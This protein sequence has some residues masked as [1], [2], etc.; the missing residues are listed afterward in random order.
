MGHFHDQFELNFCPVCG[1]RLRHELL[2][3]NEPPRLRCPDCGFILYQDPKV[4]ACTV[5][6]MPEGIVLLKRGINPRKGKWVIP[7]GYVERGEKVEHAALRETEEECG[8]R[9]EI[10][11]L[12]GIY[13]YTGIIPVVIVYAARPVSGKLSA[14]DETIEAAL[15]SRGNIPWDDLAFESTEKALRDYLGTGEVTGKTEE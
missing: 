6:E 7:G 13:S 10:N 8:I 15:F 12:L 1:G 4:V 2:K 11:G 14:R 9:C 3:E 5:V